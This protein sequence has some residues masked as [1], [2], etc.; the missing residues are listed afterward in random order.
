MLKK[1]SIIHA[2]RMEVDEH[3]NCALIFEKKAY[4]ENLVV[5]Y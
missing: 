3:M 2:S 4:W 5:K 1:T